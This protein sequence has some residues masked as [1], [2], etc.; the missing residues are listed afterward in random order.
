MISQFKAMAKTLLVV[1]CLITSNMSY[2]QK[3][4]TVIVTGY[5]PPFVMQG[6]NNQL[7]GF[8]IS[9][10][11][12]I[13]QLTKHTC[14]IQRKEFDQL[15]PLV[16]QGKAD[17]AISAIS[18][19][20]ERAQ[21]IYFSIPYMLS[22]GSF[23]ADKTSGIKTINRTTLQGKT[24]GVIKGTVFASELNSMNLTGITYHLYD[25]QHS[26]ID[27]LA[28]K[29]I[30]LAVLDEPVANYWVTNSGDR[31]KQVGKHFDVGFGL[32]IVMNKENTRLHQQVNQAIKYIQQSG[33]FSSYYKKFF[34]L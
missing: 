20:A 4:L 19:T 15:I 13:C 10:I 7:F 2:S 25:D 16:A 11:Y 18:I 23:L 33:Q 32:A 29:N 21:Y 5:N 3:E 1:Y 22:Q 24:V 31:F 6:G 14:K 30:D 17:M 28:K 8:D 9:L 34:Q 26:M 12:K 27:G